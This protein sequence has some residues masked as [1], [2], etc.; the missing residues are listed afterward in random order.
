MVRVVRSGAAVTVTVTCGP[1]PAG[2]APHATGSGTG[3]VGLDERIR[4]AGGVLTHGPLPDGGFEVTASLPL[5]PGPV[6]AARARETSTSARELARERRQ[7][8]R[9]LKQAIWVPLAV[10]AALGVLIGAAALNNRY[11]SVLDRSR[12]DLVRVGDSRAD[13][14]SRLPSYAMDGAPDGAPPQP[15]G[16]D[17]VYYRTGPFVSLPAYRLCFT[18]EVLASK[19]VVDAAGPE[20][21]AAGAACPWHAAPAASEQTRVRPG[22][23]RGSAS[24][25]P[26]TGCSCPRGAASR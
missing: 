7:V 23:P 19:A 17:C 22:C 11:G 21:T 20:R 13:L 2:P 18:G 6:L 3:L 12:Y 16:Q 24:P 25:R 26:R 5:V 10:T 14:G 1:C 15:T 8:R 9:R 4:L